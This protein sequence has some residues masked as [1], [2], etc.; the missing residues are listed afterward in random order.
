MSLALEGRWILN[1]WTTREAS[2]CTC[3]SH[4]Q[5]T[6]V[7]SSIHPQQHLLFFHQKDYS[8]SNGCGVIPGWLALCICFLSWGEVSEGRTVPVELGSERVQLPSDW[9]G[10]ALLPLLVPRVLQEASLP[11]SSQNSSERLGDLLTHTQFLTWEGVC[12]FQGPLL[13]YSFFAVPT[14]ILESNLAT[15]WA[16][17]ATNLHAGHR[18]PTCGHIEVET[19]A[20]VRIKFL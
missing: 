10:A 5:C 20:E 2:P 7:P 1:H 17:K 6:R 19:W 18:S 15:R 3:H 4:Q 11:L 12:W 8:Y 16:K 13:S 9:L 14:W